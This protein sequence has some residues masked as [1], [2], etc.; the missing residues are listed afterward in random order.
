MQNMYLHGGDVYRR[1]VELDFSINVNPFGMPE[2]VRQ[3]AMEGVRQSERYPDWAAEKL[4]R[5]AAERFQLPVSAVLPGNGAAELIYALTSALRPRR[6]F[7]LAPGFMEYEQALA[8]Q[9][10]R[11]Y[12]IPLREEENYQPDV[13][14]I[15]TA[16]DEMGEEDLL[17]L[18]NPNNPTGTVLP[19][20]QL[21]LIL[22]KVEQKNGYLTMDECF[23]PFLLEEEALTL[24]PWLTSHPRLCILRALTK[25]YAMP[26]LRLGLLLSG[27][28]ELIHRI[29]QQL[30]PWNVSVPA[31]LAGEKAFSQKDYVEKTKRYIAAERAWLVEEM[32]S[33]CEK[34]FPGS[35]NFIFFRADPALGSGLLERGI[36]IRDCSSFAGLRKGDYRICV[37]KHEDNL[38]VLERWR[39]WQNPS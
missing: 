3:A 37:G 11:V 31:Q 34:V 18:C 1:P 22:E 35:G 4:C 15:L 17:F 12:R 14:E 5:A 33:L 19:R 10:A 13:S 9:K 16:L 36:L 23:L 28:E 8:A 6:G 25:I 32:R 7:V 38:T 20:E 24:V 26:G 21:L 39:E 29:R 30:Q 2:A 27:N